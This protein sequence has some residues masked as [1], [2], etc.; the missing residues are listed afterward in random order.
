MKNKYSIFKIIIFVYIFFINI[1]YS[2]ANDLI[3]D[4]EV[5]DIKDKGNVIAATGS[6]KISDG[7]KLEINGKEAIYNKINQFLEVE[8]EVVFFD[9]IK[10][11]KAFSDKIVFDRNK[12]IVSSFGNTIIR[13]LDKNNI[14][15]IFEIKGNNS[16]LNIEKELFE[17]NNNVIFKDFDNSFLILSEEII[18][19]RANQFIKSLG[20]TNI[21]YKNDF[22]IST[23]DISFNQKNKEFISKN[24]TKV[25]D[26]FQNNFE[27]SSFNFNLEKKIFKSEN[28]KLIDSEKNI[29]KLSKAYF[30]ISKNELIGSDY[31]LTFNKG[32]FGNFENDPRMSGRYINTNK[33]E[34]KMKKS[35]FTTCKSFKGKCPAWSLSA[36]EITHKREQKRIEYKNAWLEIYDVPVAYFPYFFH[37][38][39]TV[40]RQSGFLFPQFLNSSNLGF[41]TQIPYYYAI[42]HD[43][44]MT[45]SP[46]IYTNDNLFLQTEYRQTFKNSNL[47]TDFSYNKKNNSDYHLF[48]S[49]KR[50]FE[51]SFYEMKIETVSDNDYLKRYQIKSPLIENYSTLN[52][53]ISYEKNTDDYSF[54][55]SVNVINNL[56]K[57]GSDQYEY[58][59]PNYEFSKENSLNGKIFETLNFSSKGNY[60]KFNTNVDEAEIINSFIF[61]SSEQ[62]QLGNIETDYSILLKNVN[63]YGDL[64]TAYKEQEDYKI[65]GTAIYNLNYP[66]IKETENGK[67][68]LTPL[69][70]LRFSPA[71]GLNLRNENKLIQFEDLFILDRI[72]NKTVEAGESLTLGLEFKNL[73]QLDNENLNLGL[74]M[75]FRR[76]EDNDLPLSSS[77]GQKT[78][79]LI[80][81]S[82]INVTENLSFNYNFS[83]EQNLSETNYSLITAKYTGNKLKTSFEYLEKSNFVGDES[84]LTN[85]TE[86]ELN[87]SNSIAFETTKNIDKNLTNYY[88]L[89]YQYKNDCLQASIVYNKQFYQD[90]S[91]NSDQNIFFKI[92]FIPFGEVGTENIND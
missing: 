8:G 23:N 73:N 67:K 63:T 79:D 62:N 40:E 70:S 35:S 34:T 48:T 49:L 88:N 53:L 54:A 44:D 58:V 91:I 32:S 60:R 3:I 6:I 56:T 24:E 25:N 1:T 28:I 30:D 85:I 50:D 16:L 76:N 51:E 55:S 61:S 2:I 65:L 21:E 38:D 14:K 9:K 87:K 84:Y 26:K 86:I 15:T 72:D 39:P 81:Y 17:I 19:D 27:L 83:I 41:S 5:V 45:I 4:A 71:S 37:P 52:S 66:L 7:Q 31:I 57:E 92:S 42:D 69:A 10:N 29:L 64:S 43:R 90:N 13:Q 11:F 46:R 89:I 77:L 80:G 75:N 59:I 68:F 36:D 74:A 78:S 82:G 12:N 33:S 20:K 22:F 18:Y 47:I